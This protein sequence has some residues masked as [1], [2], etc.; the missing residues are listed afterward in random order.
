MIAGQ[1]EYENLGIAIVGIAVQDYKEEIRKLLNNKASGKASRN[2]QLKNI[3][4]AGKWFETEWA[5][6]LGVRDSETIKKYARMEVVEKRKRYIKK[7]LREQKG[8]Y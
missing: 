2:I 4:Q 5:H 6:T 3:K 7:R 1:K 8:S